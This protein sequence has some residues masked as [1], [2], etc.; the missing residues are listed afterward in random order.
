M[1]RASQWV[2]VTRLLPPMPKF[3][4]VRQL[5]KLSH[6]DLAERCWAAEVNHDFA[7][8]SAGEWA[9]RAAELSDMLEGRR[10]VDPEVLKSM[11]EHRTHVVECRLGSCEHEFAALVRA[12]AISLAFPGAPPKGAT[13]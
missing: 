5:R 13:L 4:T 11:N 6:R 12:D 2:W 1:S 7:A 3:R 8:E 9:A 10:P